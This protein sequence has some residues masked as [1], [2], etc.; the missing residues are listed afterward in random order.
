MPDATAPNGL[1]APNAE[2]LAAIAVLALAIGRG[3][4]KL[5]DAL[6]LAYG[7]ENHRCRRAQN[8]DP[9]A[10]SIGLA[11]VRMSPIA[12]ASVLHCSMLAPQP[13]L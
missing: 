13:I 5:S 2:Q 11:L 4:V 8:I 7:P 6:L 9:A 3:S 10:N 12:L 1:P